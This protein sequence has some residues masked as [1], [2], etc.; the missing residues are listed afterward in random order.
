[1]T[2]L[3]FSI[4]GPFLY[5]IT[6]NTIGRNESNPSAFQKVFLGIYLVL[7]CLFLLIIIA[8]QYNRYLSG[9]RSATIFILVLTFWGIVYWLIDRRKVF[10]NVFR[11]LLFCFAVLMIAVSPFF[12][13]RVLGDAENELIYNDK[14]YRLESVIGFMSPCLLPNLYVKNGIIEKRL[15]PIDSMIYPC[16]VK[17]DISH[18]KTETINDNKV[19]FTYFFSAEKNESLP[20]SLNVT[21]YE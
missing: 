11:T 8:A 12:I 19:A 15:N 5:I 13:L 18:V 1:M 21:Y 4:F 6:R 2:F 20:D 16:F 7:L 14:S 10:T 9:F 3:A 17:K